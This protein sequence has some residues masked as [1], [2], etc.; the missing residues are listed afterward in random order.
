M[1]LEPPHGPVQLS[2]SVRP[3]I[4][5]PGEKIFV[6]LPDGRLWTAKNY[7]RRVWYQHNEGSELRT[8]YIV[9]PCGGTFIGTSNWADM[10]GTDSQVVGVQSDGSLWQLLSWEHSEN[11]S[12]PE[13]NSANIAVITKA[14]RIGTDSNWKKVAAAN[15]GPREPRARSYL[16]H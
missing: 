1:T 7:E 9:V 2:G 11:G 14:E 8:N 10:A 12:L 5:R 4:C 3:R 15:R 16:R 13:R 6:L